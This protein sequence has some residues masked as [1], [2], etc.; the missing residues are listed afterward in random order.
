MENGLP[1]ARN[2]PVLAGFLALLL[3]ALRVDWPV[4]RSFCQRMRSV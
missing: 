1:W 4:M 2:T 3:P